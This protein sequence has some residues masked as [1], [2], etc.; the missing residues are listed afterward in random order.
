MH[1]IAGPDG[2]GRFTSSPE[3]AP[4][5]SSRS[6]PLSSILIGEE[7][8]LVECARILQARAHQIVAV[9][10]RS[11]P[12]AEW[13]RGEGIALFDT[14]GALLEAG[15]DA[16]DYL[17]SI[18]N[19]AV[20]PAPVLALAS[21]AAIN[22][23]DGPL[24]AY[25][26]LNTPVWALLAGERAHGVTWHLMA[27]AVDGGDILA[28]EPVPVDA[29]ETALSLNTK[30][31][32]A[33]LHSFARLATTLAHA[34]PRG[35]PQSS[36][37]VRMYGRGDRPEAAATIDWDA[38]AEAIARQVSALDFGPY[39]NPLGCPKAMLGDRL[40]LVRRVEVLATRSGAAPGT[41]VADGPAPV[42]ATASDDLR[43]TDLADP[44]GAPLDGLAD[45]RGQRFAAFDA[46]CRTQLNALDS[47]A[48]RYEGWW[49]R[50]LAARDALQLAGFQPR[51]AGAVAEPVVE[52][53]S[54]PAGRT[55]A[56]LLAAMVGY[57][58]RVADRDTVDIGY[59][60]PVFRSRLE[61]VG[62]WFAAQLPLRVALDW[63]RPLAALGDRL[64]GEI[65]GMHKRVAIA[66]D[67]IARSPE[68]RGGA[69]FGHPVAV[70]MVDTL[71]EACA[72]PDTVL[73]LAIRAD[74]AACRLIYDAARYDR[75]AAQNFWLGF[76]AM[77]AADD[78]APGTALAALSL[79]SPAERERVEAWNATAEEKP[80]A[81]ALH[82]LF[83]VQAACTPD[84]VAVTSRGVSLTYAELDA[85]SNRLARHLRGLGAGP[86]V[87]VGIN[88]ERSVEVVVALLAVHKAGAAY[89]PL[90]PAY[91]AERLAHM[92]A[93]SQMALIVTQGSLAGALPPGDAF[94]VDI[95]AAHNA[96]ASL[97]AGPIDGGAGPDNL[98]YVIYTSGST[99]RPK[100]VMVEHRNALTFFAGMDR[101]LE[102]DGVWLAVT[103]LSFDISLLELVWPLTRGYQVVIATEREVRG[104]VRPAAQ[105]RT[106]SFS[107]F[108]FA[109]SNSASQAEDY[110]LLLDGARF[111]DA[112][113]FEAIWTPERHFHAFGAPYPNPSVTSAALAAATSRIKIRA[114]S[115]VAP[116]HHP[117]R[118]A[119]E[120]A[121]VD[122]FSNG[123]VGISFASGWQPNDFVLNPGAFA[124]RNAAMMRTVEDVR[125][126]WRGEKRAF[127]GALG[128]DV[129][130]ATYPRPVQP[131]LPVWI[132]SAGNPETFAQTGRAGAFILTHMLGQKLD[133]VAEKIAVYRAA[134]RDA[135]HPG[136]GH[137]TLMLHSFVGE[138]AASV[139]EIVRG[140]LIE[141]LRTSTNLLRQYAW[142][143]PAFK[144]P[145]GSDASEA[146]ELSQLS[147]ED[148]EALLEHA[149]ERYFETS[150]LFGTPE[151]CRE[152]V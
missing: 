9:V 20:L 107:L 97:P 125:A 63:D 83:V 102:P 3:S 24:P 51:P 115:V 29:A 58:G 10:A 147:E 133:E 60:D 65:G 129:E 113:G 4:L 141:Y 35:R 19:L 93:D 14:P 8:L 112:N 36:A 48:G 37:P 81:A 30:C 89:V 56:D 98:A 50:R 38:P 143:F 70:Q 66:R 73:H 149:F 108:Y 120:W 6:R 74:G 92:I 54:V 138:D 12:A 152:F 16:V 139:R 140:P 117:I 34:A 18:T 64:A 26:G 13:A 130:V 128:H 121:L 67:L 76:R 47:A 53:R 79:L 44:D 31:F 1:D 22:F 137:V 75:A 144:K 57:L 5:A 84:R 82:R 46:D 99:G 95:D 33:G 126:L 40:V 127:P 104:D 94:V 27:E 39:A 88:L 32:E 17:F 25:A 91:P 52:D 134:W 80:A 135:G 71:D 123:R 136:E 77:L 45:T 119:E 145:A 150:G 146:V 86:E 114:G 61:Q 69:G 87:L 124:D 55:G 105:A 15:L 132:T 2:I 131:E 148:T 85:R 118:I 109:S 110:R 59:A 43:L 7:T 78:A 96:I 62:G 68:L 72:E 106:A 90:D 151:S 28:A 142:S 41:V 116:L 103:S 100:G 23:H 11:G 49:R 111:A 101:H 42:V 122:N 21:R